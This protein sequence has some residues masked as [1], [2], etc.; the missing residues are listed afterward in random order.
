M[1]NVS[2]AVIKKILLSPD[3]C[4]IAGKF[5]RGKD[6]ILALSVRN[7]INLSIKLLTFLEECQITKLKT[8]FKKEAR[9]DPKNYRSISLLQSVSKIIEKSIY[10]QI[11]DY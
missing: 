8:I 4:K 5:L 2:E 1:S 7:I 3:N 9:T 11:E 6:D 10:F